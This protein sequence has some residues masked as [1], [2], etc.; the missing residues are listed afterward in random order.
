MNPLYI[1]LKSR[2]GLIICERHLAKGGVDP[3]SPAYRRR[4]APYGGADPCKACAI[5]AALKPPAAPPSA[6]PLGPAS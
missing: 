1:D 5:A 2:H 3:A 4:F 6:I